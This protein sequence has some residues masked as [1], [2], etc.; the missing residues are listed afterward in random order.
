MDN[1]PT[2]AIFFDLGNT[3]VYYSAAWPESFYQFA[4]PVCDFLHSNGFCLDNREFEQAL[5][6]EIVIHEPLEAEGFREETAATVMERLIQRFSGRSASPELVHQTLRVMYTISETMWIPEE[7]ALPVLRELKEKGYKLGIISNASD[8]EDV[9]IL[10]DKVGARP[11]MDLVLSSAAFGYGKPVRS[12]FEYALGK[13]GV[14]ADQTVMV[15]DTLRSDILGAN[16]CGM[17]SIWLTRRARNLGHPIPPEMMPWRTIATL[18][19]L[20]GL[21]NGGM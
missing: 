18:G 1:Q 8:D 17:R 4:G 13:V 21:F 16:R 5:L 6:K 14:T 9:Q 20:T 11:Y 2:Q 12:I 15:G 10:T 3:L 19:E 7:D